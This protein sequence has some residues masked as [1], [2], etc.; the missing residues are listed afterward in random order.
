MD[1]DQRRFEAALK[2]SE[3]ITD[4]MGDKIH[5][6]EKLAGL[7]VLYADALLTRLTV[8]D[9]TADVNEQMQV[10]RGW[11]PR[12]AEILDAFPANRIGLRNEALEAICIALTA[13]RRSRSATIPDPA[14]WLMQRATAFREA[15]H[16]AKQRQYIPMAARWFREAGYDSPPETW[17]TLGR[18]PKDRTERDEN[19]SARAY[20]AKVQ[21]QEMWK[22]EKASE[23]Q[24]VA[25]DAERWAGIM[26]V[27]E[28]LRGQD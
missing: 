2:F 12:A 6:P 7:S 5:L 17:A 8:R 13:L 25:D 9:I 23:Q 19:A 26:R 22:Q 14:A 20:D 4:N 10:N 11:M 24:Q 1:H 28:A 21:Q 15:T 3:I 16:T 27:K 18:D